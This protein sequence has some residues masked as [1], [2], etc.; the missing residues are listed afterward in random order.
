MK[1]DRYISISVA[2]DDAELNVSRPTIYKAI[3]DGKL[4]TWKVSGKMLLIKNTKYYNYER[5]TRGIQKKKNLII[6]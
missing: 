5:D 4:D 6:D 1:S 3:N 2:A